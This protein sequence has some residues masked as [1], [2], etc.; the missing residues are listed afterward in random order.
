MGNLSRCTEVWKLEMTNKSA[1]IIPRTD[2]C[3]YCGGPLLGAYWLIGEGP[4]LW[5]I[6]PSISPWHL[7]SPTR[8]EKI[9]CSK[10]K[11]QGH[12][13]SW[14]VFSPPRLY[15]CNCSPSRNTK[16]LKLETKQQQDLNWSSWSY[17]VIL[18][19]IQA[20][21]L[22]SP[23]FTGSKKKCQ[24]EHHGYLKRHTQSLEKGHLD[25]TG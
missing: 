4:E 3:W 8:L 18:K 21:T 15:R 23:S 6:W 22:A 2:V 14:W 12:D 19:S 24:G 9:S 1:L 7:T 10:S 25:G 17:C 13:C 5:S 11:E 20:T 16:H